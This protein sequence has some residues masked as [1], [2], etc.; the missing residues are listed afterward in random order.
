MQN[1]IDRLESL[2]LSLMTNGAQSTGPSAATAVIS[3]S[4][5]SGSRQNTAE[6]DINE[7]DMYGKDDESDTEQVTKS[8]GIMKVDNKN[9]KSYYVSE[10]HCFSILNDVRR[11]PAL[12]TTRFKADIAQIAE[13]RQYFVTHK[14]QFEAQMEKVQAAS[15]DQDFSG[16]ALVFG[17]MKPPS[18]AEIMSS[19]PSK[20]TTDILISRYFNTYDPAIRACFMC[21]PLHL[22]GSL[23]SLRYP[24]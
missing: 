21:W 6:V 22:F 17:P 1:R 18:Q 11:P 4:G 15:E 2:V 12:V 13:V 9:E 7:G 5:S 10:A 16:P 24:P 8:F 3:G 19:F 20:Y 23:T 14:E